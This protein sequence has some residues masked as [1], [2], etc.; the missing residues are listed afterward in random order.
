MSL[1]PDMI[2]EMA[3]E[4]V[5]D[6][7]NDEVDAL[8][9]KAMAEIEEFAQESGLHLSESRLTSLSATITSLHSYGPD[10]KQSMQINF[11]KDLTKRLTSGRGDARIVVC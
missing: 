7:L 4:R 5:L 6:D 2:N 11:K 3:M 9:S 1:D 10:V 8:D